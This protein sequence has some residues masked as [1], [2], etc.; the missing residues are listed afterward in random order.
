M[1]YFVF[2]YFCGAVYDGQIVSKMQSAVIATL[3][4]QELATAKWKENGEK[5]DFD[6]FVDIAH[7]VSRELEHSDLNLNRLEKIC[8]KTPIFQGN[9]LKRIVIRV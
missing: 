2:T 9:S 7:R 5:L 1:V 6:G 3:L 8:E 4:I